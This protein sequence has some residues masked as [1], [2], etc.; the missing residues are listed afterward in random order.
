MLRLP[1]LSRQ[2]VHSAESGI[3][4]AKLGLFEHYMYILSKGQVMHL[5][6]SW[7]QV[8]GGGKCALAVG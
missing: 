2:A 6:I 7:Q 3:A 1:K 5:V 4:F 8:G